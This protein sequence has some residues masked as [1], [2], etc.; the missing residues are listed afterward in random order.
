MNFSRLWTPN[1]SAG[2]STWLIIVSWIALWMV[3]WIYGRPIIMPS[4][5]EVLSALPDLWFHDGLGDALV[6]SLAANLQAVA[7]SAAITLPLAYMSRVPTVRPL[8]HGLS[9]LRFLSPVV[10][11]TLL[12]FMLRNGYQVKITMLVLGQSFFLL[13]TMAGVV[14]QIPNGQFDDARTLRMGEWKATYYVVVRGTLPQALEAI[15]DSAAMSWSMVMFV[16]GIVQSG[17][18]VGLLLRANQKY[19]DFAPLFAASLAIL[20]VGLAEDWVFG[21]VRRTVCPYVLLRK[22]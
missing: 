15:K 17:G 14:A 13:T 1:E 6:T 22:R 12:V 4:P 8:A 18:G 3:L 21:W 5:V 20:V 9:L 16:E 7:I 11:Y 10:A 19:Q 2:R